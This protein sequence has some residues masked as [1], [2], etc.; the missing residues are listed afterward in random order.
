[1]ASPRRCLRSAGASPSRRI[2]WPTSV[3]PIPATAHLPSNALRAFPARA[4]C[5]DRIFGRGQTRLIDLMRLRVPTAAFAGRCCH[6]LHRVVIVSGVIDRGTQFARAR[7]RRAEDFVTAGYQMTRFSSSRRSSLAFAGP[8]FLLLAWALLAPAGERA[9]WSHLVTSGTNHGRLPSFIETLAIDVAGGGSEHGKSLP[10][11]PP[12]QRCSESWCSEQPAA[13]AVPVGAFDARPDFRPWRAS[14]PLC[15]P[16][17][18]FFVTPEIRA[19]RSVHRG[20]FVFHPP[21]LHLV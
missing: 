11:P 21:R 9:G 20:T 14:I 6:V 10:G 7:F 19:A 2:G 1:M 12:P 3:L 15:V 17:G 8:V 13:P 16:I 18:P 4:H 5:F